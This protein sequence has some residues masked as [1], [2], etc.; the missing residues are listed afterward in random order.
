MVKISLALLTA[1]SAGMQDKLFSVIDFREINKR[2]LIV[3]LWN[4]Y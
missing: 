4:R 1:V 3:S 2:V